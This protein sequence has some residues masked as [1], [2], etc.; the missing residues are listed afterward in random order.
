MSDH[1]LY[2]HGVCVA[3]KRRIQIPMSDY[4]PE[5]GLEG[6]CEDCE[7]RQWE[8]LRHL[9]SLPCVQCCVTCGNEEPRIEGPKIK[10]IIASCEHC[11][12]RG[13]TS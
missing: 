6:I 10:V 11:A 8:H 7:R 4:Q 2:V 5:L 9:A 1:A 12:S 13:G 3:C